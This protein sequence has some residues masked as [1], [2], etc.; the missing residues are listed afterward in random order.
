VFST[1]HLRLLSVILLLAA[2]T[3][4]A[5]GSSAAPKPSGVSRSSV[6]NNNHHDDDDDNGPQRTLIRK[7]ALVITMDPSLGTGPLGLIENGDVLFEGDHIVAVGQNLSADHADVINA[8]GKIVM[9][10]FIETHNH[11]WQTVVRGCESDEAF[12]AWATGCTRPLMSGTGLLTKEEVYAAVRLGTLDA[13]GT[14]TTTSVEFSH[15]PS[16]DFANGT[17]D[18]LEDSGMRFFLAYRFRIGREAHVRSIFH[19]RIETNP[20]A[21]LQIGGPL[22]TSDPANLADLNASIVMAREL[23]VMLHLHFLETINDRAANP[24]GVLQ[25]STNV[26]DGTFD[27]RLLLGHAIH[28]TDAELDML[29]A[30]DARIAHNPL[31]NMRLASGVIRLPQMHERNM[32][33][34]LGYDGGTNDTSDMFNTMRTAMG[35][36]RATT[37]N[38]KIYPGV[39]DVLRMSTLGGAEVLGIADKVGSLTPG[40]KA[41]IIILDPATVNFAP[42]VDWV[43]QIVLNGQPRNV[44]WVFVNGE[45]LMKKG[46]FVGVD[47]EEVIQEA[48]AAVDRINTRL[49]R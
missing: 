28:V 27:G 23:G 22:A 2:I 14:G 31:S 48:E 21:G 35:L 10:G 16:L 24:V 4:G 7:A 38:A 33:V 17:L 18:A 39:N 43:S 1:R 19:D 44:Q 47:E 37:L 29:T 9:P 42:Q 36:Q 30:H 12:D 11:M 26:F 45:T 41:D 8:K 40:K 20:V 3:F 46:K 34:G 6:T 5:I 13:I 25:S 32:K 15:A 49:G